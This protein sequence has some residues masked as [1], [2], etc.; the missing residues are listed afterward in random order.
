MTSC[1]SLAPDFA[2]GEDG[3]DGHEDS[4]DGLRM[5]LAGALRGGTGDEEIRTFRIAE[6][7]A[8]IAW[9]TAIN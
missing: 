5:E 8:T 9:T 7:T 6:Q 1:C 3:G 2:A 4:D